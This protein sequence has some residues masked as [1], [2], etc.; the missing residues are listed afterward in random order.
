M[1]NRDNA[2]WREQNFAEPAYIAGAAG[3]AEYGSLITY[4]LA[5]VEE[6]RYSFEPAQ[7]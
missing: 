3:V 7:S 2:G 6:D 1:R 4:T 5:S